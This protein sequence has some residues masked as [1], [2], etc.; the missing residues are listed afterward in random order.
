MTQFINTRC[1]IAGG[2]PAGMMLGFLLARAALICDS[3]SQCE[4]MG[5]LH[6]ALAA[7]AIVRDRVRAEL[8]EIVT[9]AKPGRLSGQE[10]VVFDSTG[11][12]VQDAAAASI[13][14]PT[15]PRGHR[16]TYAA[17]PVPQKS[18][19]EI[20]GCWRCPTD[21]MECAANRQALMAPLARALKAFV[22]VEFYSNSNQIIM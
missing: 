3:I 12:A 9:G 11:L 8:S 10:I 20:S 6:Q 16:A 13:G 4:T 2:G 22:F 1:C 5:D 14:T 17:K 18:A 7:G 15:T 21:Y 19:K